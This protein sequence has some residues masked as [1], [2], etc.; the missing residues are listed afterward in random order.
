MIKNN[1]IVEYSVY[2]N[3][4][5]AKY[6]ECDIA[7]HWACASYPTFESAKKYAELFIG[8][9]IYKL[10]RHWNGKPYKFRK[11]VNNFDTIEI[12][13]IQKIF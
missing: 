9:L 4:K 1:L 12:K 11:D 6:P 10:P 8:K 5:L 3:G 7:K 2:Y 13:E